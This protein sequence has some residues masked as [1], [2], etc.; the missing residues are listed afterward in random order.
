M[1]KSF[2]ITNCIVLALLPSLGWAED[3]ST[4]SPSASVSL[5][6]LPTPAEATEPRGA[7]TLRNSL[8]QPYEYADNKPYRLSQQERQRLREQLRGQVYDTS[9]K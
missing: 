3:K 6:V 1:M 9:K 8:R 2:L 4:P 7:D 5:L